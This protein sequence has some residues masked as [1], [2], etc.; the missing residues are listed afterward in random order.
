[1]VITKCWQQSPYWDL[2]APS[3]T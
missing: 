3:A 2:S 1:M